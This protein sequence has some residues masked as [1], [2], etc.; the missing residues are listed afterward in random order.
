VPAGHAVHKPAPL[1]LYCPAL[2][3][4]AVGLTDPATHAYPAVQLPL[5][6]ALVRPDV[7]PK[8]PAG[9]ALHMPAPAREY[10]PATHIAAV[11]D[12]LPV[13]H[14]Y[15]A[16]QFPLHATVAS[17][18]TAPYVPAGHAEQ[19]AAPAR[20]Y[21]PGGHCAVQDDVVKPLLLPYAPAGQLVHAVDPA[22]EYLP[23]PQMPVQ[24]LT[25]SP[26]VPP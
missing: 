9:H 19:E 23:M 22:V 1:K 24:V 3:T 20:L 5:Q 21:V 10:C 8:V 12:T 15:P 13:T 26:V 18:A 17:P 11:G 16:V 25:D 7:A 4:A 2:H 6:D 14:A